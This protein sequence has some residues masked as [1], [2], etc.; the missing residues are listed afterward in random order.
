MRTIGAG[1]AEAGKPLALF[2]NTEELANG[3]YLVK[4]QT[5]Y[6]VATARLVVSR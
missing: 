2:L 1:T 3:I 5:G 4:L 6:G